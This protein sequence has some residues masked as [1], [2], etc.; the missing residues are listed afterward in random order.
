MCK[1]VLCLLFILSAVGTSFSQS[2]DVCDVYGP[3][4]IT[5]KPHEANLRVFVEESEAFADLV[6]FKEENVLFADAKGLWAFAK[7]KS[8]AHYI[9]YIDKNKDQAD[10]S[11]FY[12]DVESFAGCQ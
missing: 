11:I 9:I 10:F 7:N 6:V 1:P 3:I 2:F 4:Y 5:D 8:F 12:T